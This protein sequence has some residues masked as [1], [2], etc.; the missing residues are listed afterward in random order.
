M[1]AVSTR[2]GRSNSW[3]AVSMGTQ[4][5]LGRLS[6]LGTALA[7]LAPDNGP[8]LEVGGSGTLA[9]WIGPVFHSDIQVAHL[10]TRRPSRD[11]S[12]AAHQRIPIP[13]SMS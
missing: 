12:A 13:F 10:G 3:P 2:G 4:A 5:A 9:P 6:V 11:A 7:R 1:I 8:H